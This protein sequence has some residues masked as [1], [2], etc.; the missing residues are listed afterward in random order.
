MTNKKE[1]MRLARFQRREKRREAAVRWMNFNTPPGYPWNSTLKAAA[2]GGVFALLWSLTYFVAY[3]DH[4]SWLFITHNGKRI[5]SEDSVMSNFADIVDGKLLGFVILMIAALGLIGLHYTYH[6][7]G[8]KSI[9]VMKRLPKK[10]E[11]WRRCITL[12]VILALISGTAAA[13]L[14]VIFYVFYMIVTPETALP[15]GQWIW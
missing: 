9:Y 8:S 15:P 10:R 14:R 4:Y 3:S 5:F 1:E 7:Q 2:W 13:V 12:P 11:L 6:Y